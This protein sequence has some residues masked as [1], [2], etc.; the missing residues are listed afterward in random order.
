MDGPPAA[1]GAPAHRMR[2]STTPTHR[3]PIRTAS[4]PALPRAPFRVGREGAPELTRGAVR[5]EVAAGDLERLGRGVVIPTRGDPDPVRR[6]A[7][8]ERLLRS[9]QASSLRCERAAIS[10]LAG[11][12]ALGLATYGALDRPCLTVPSGTALRH[13]AGAHLHRAGL[14][15]EDVVE[16]DGYDVLAVA[17]TV[18]DVARECGVTAGVVAADSA[19]HDKRVDCDELQATLERCAWWP[20]QRRA[21][22]TVGLADGRAESPLES[23]SRLRLLDAGLPVPELQVEFCDL[24]GEYIT[25]SDFYWPEFG[26]VG[27]ADGESKY[28]PDG[29]VRRRQ[30]QTQ[31]LLE[32][33]GLE[34]VRWGWADLYPFTQT[35]REIERACRRGP[36]PG[37]PRRRWGVLL[38]R[39]A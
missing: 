8:E 21:R 32:R 30:E 3:R 6:R 23:V 18:L 11:A 36:R 13:L 20:G 12:V 16:I 14:G 4:R 19:L 1:G 24:N 33:T 34:V 28:D 39:A 35:V 38:P 5:H 10:H 2:M 25:R 7:E 22:A 17:R 26:V 27:E 37:S 15:P 9:A 29:R 31:T